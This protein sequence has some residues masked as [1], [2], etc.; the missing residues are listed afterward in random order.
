MLT[1]AAHSD[2]HNVMG[3][4]SGMLIE[5]LRMAVACR[6]SIQQVGAGHDEVVLGYTGC[7]GWQASLV[8]RVLV[9]VQDHI[10]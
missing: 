6:C 10:D 8:G 9:A 3:T 1:S 2:V 5:C 7:P 4:A